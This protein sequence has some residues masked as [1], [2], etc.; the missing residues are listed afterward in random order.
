MAAAESDVTV[1]LAE[2]TVRFN[3]DAYGPYYLINVG[4]YIV[5][6]LERLCSSVTGY[7]WHLTY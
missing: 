2:L 6:T 3:A 5:N 4:R 7:P 1:N